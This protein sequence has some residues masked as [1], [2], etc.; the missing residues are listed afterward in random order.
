[1]IIRPATPVDVPA[2][3][4]IAVDTGMFDTDGAGFVGDVVSGILDGSLHD[5]HVVV[6]EASDGAVVGAAYFAPEPFSDRMWNLYFIAVHPSR[7]GS[8]IGGR[9]RGGAGPRRR[10]L[11]DRHVRADP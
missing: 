2:I 6:H 3:E 4:T 1:M 8:G 7:Q 9:P 10:D 11:L 5:H